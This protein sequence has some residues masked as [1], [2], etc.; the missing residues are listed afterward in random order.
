MKISKVICHVLEVPISAQ[1]YSQVTNCVRDAI[2]VEIETVDGIVG[3]GECWGVPKIAKSYID[4]I[5]KP[6]LIGEDP[7]NINKIYYKMLNETMRGGPNY[8]LISGI[9]MALYDIIGKDTGKPLHQLLGGA[10]RDKVK[11]YASGG[12]K[13]ESWKSFASWRGG[14]VDFVSSFKE[15][16][17]DTIKIKVGFDPKKDIL[18]VK[19]LRKEVGYDINIAIDAN[20]AWSYST[21]RS[22]VHALQSENIAWL[23]EPM[24]IRDHDNYRKLRSI[25]SIPIS[26]GE[27]LDSLKSFKDVIQ[28]DSVDIIQPD[29]MWCGGFK[30]F[31]KVLALAEA[32]NIR[33]LPHCWST[34]ILFSATASF[35]STLPGG[36]A[37]ITSIEEPMMEYDCSENILRTE[38]FEQNLNVQSGYLHL[39]NMPGIGVSINRRALKKFVL[40]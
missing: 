2:I 26:G 17:F 16:G 8:G 22:V 7:N 15:S 39:T 23:E 25:S 33:F 9:E 21:S 3:W 38:L 29:L 20:C 28:N 1:D 18:L 5:I 19:E 6:I 10:V 4:N 36:L 31:G 34:N 37:W 14:I 40:K 32:H 30:G 24:P 11:V 27:G 13:L 12:Y 35:M